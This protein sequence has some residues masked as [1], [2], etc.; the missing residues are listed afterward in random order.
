MSVC[1]GRGALDITTALVNHP[2]LGE[3]LDERP[4]FAWRHVSCER[5]VRLAEKKWSGQPGFEW[6]RARAVSLQST[7]ISQG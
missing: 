5:L 6:T 1:G 3:A 7:C 4:S 2:E